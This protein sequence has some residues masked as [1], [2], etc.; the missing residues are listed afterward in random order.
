MVP[1]MVPTAAEWFVLMLFVRILHARTP[2]VRIAA[3]TIARGL[4]LI[5][6]AMNGHFHLNALR[7][8]ML[9]RSPP[10][11]MQALCL[12]EVAIAESV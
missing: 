12:I 5:V 9:R 10:L 6:S 1:E 8:L 3:S 2:H 4:P 7:T 11:T